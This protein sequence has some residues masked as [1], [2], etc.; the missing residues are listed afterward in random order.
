[1]KVGTEMTEIHKTWGEGSGNRR[2]TAK[3]RKPT[4][5]CGYALEAALHAP[6]LTASD[7]KVELARCESVRN[8]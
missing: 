5:T 7:E 3:V 2:K 4:I 6:E 8:R 1:M